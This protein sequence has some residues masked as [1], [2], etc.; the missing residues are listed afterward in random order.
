MSFTNTWIF[1]LN[2]ANN[3]PQKVLFHSLHR[4]IIPPAE[5]CRHNYKLTISWKH[6]TGLSLKYVLC[7]FQCCVGD[8]VSEHFGEWGK[9]GKAHN[10]TGHLNKIFCNIS[11][12][13]IYRCNLR[14]IFISKS[15]SPHRGYKLKCSAIE[16]HTSSIVLWSC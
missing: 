3:L 7:E 6:L 11:Y 10:T 2:K 15:T 12:D 14:R 16:F 5:I 4:L 13:K 1:S 9:E 8:R